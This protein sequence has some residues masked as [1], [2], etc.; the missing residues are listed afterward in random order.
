M[1]VLEPL[2]G[3]RVPLWCGKVCGRG[4]WGHRYCFFPLGASDR[5]LGPRL[6][7]VCVYMGVV[8]VLCDSDGYYVRCPCVCQHHE[9]DAAVHLPSPAFYRRVHNYSWGGLSPFSLLWF[10]L[11]ML[12]YGWVGPVRSLRVLFPR[13][14]LRVWSFRYVLRTRLFVSL[15]LWGRWAGVC[16]GLVGS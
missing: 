14:W 1:C 9:L 11:Y 2:G 8:G 16:S 3:I 5:S 10:L 13:V 4:G 15:C 6:S 7:C 12:V